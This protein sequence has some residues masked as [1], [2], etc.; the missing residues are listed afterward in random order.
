MSGCKTHQMRA[1]LDEA[2]QV[3]GT[4]PGPSLG[5]LS[6][7]PL[8]GSTGRNAGKYLGTVRYCRTRKLCRMY[9]VL[10][11]LGGK[12]H[13][14]LQW[15]HHSPHQICNIHNEMTGGTKTAISLSSQELTIPMGQGGSHPLSA[16]REGSDKQWGRSPIHPGVLTSGQI[17]ALWVLKLGVVSSK[18]ATRVRVSPK[19]SR[20]GIN[21]LYSSPLILCS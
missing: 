16:V 5:P 13:I 18:E 14:P 12:I 19:T 8:R 17:V 10:F 7:S 11:H 4:G 20:D 21:R 2:A 6:P 15:N 1:A 9:C 3:E